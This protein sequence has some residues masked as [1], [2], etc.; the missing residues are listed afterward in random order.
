MKMIHSRDDLLKQLESA[1][2]VGGAHPAR[3][4]RESRARLAAFVE[5]DRDAERLFAEAKALDTVLARA[6]AGPASG[7]CAA[8]ILAAC[9]ELPQQCGGGSAAILPFGRI[10]GR[11]YRNLRADMP[12]GGAAFWGG[13]AML[14]ASLMLGVYIGASGEAMPTIRS[15]ELL[16]SNDMDAGIAFSG[17][18]FEPREFG[19]MREPL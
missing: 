15:I 12:G 7:G 2:S 3:W 16:A 13:A 18:V 17:A 5:T 9:L 8:K 19:E 10:R 6:C 4:P 14:A 1:L 11:Q